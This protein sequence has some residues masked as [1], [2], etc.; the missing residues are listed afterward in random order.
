MLKFIKNYLFEILIFFL[1]IGI[2]ITNYVPGT[3]LIGWDSLQT[4]LYPWL[5][6]KRALFSV[7]QE[8]QSFGLVTGM[9]HAADIIRAIFLFLISFV[10]KENLVR[11]F[12]HHLMLLI[13][14][15]GAFKLFSFLGFKSKHSFL[16]YIGAVFYILNL[17]TVQIFALPFE[18]FSV[19]FAFLP[20]LIITF[21]TY[22]QST[23]H[24]RK[25]ILGFLIINL[26]ATPAFYQQ[27]MFIVYLIVISL[28]SFG[29]MLR[30]FF[31][32]KYKEI[33]R[34][35]KNS[36]FAIFFIV[37]INTFWILPQ[38]YSIRSS[39]SVTR[40][41]KINQL[42]TETVVNK[43]IEKGKL[44]YLARLE[45]FYYDLKDINQNYLFSSWRG[46]FDNKF[47]YVLSFIPF[48]F[49]V[50]GLVFGKK[51][52]DVSFASVF[53][54][55]FLIFMSGTVPF[56]LIWEAIRGLSLIGQIF[57]SP[58][59]KF[60]FPFSLVISYFFIVGLDVLISFIIR[61]TRDRFKNMIFYTICILALAS[62]FLLN[63]PAFRG[64]FFL[65]QMKLTLPDQYTELVTYFK[66]LDSNKRIAPIPDYTFW[67][68]Y[69]NDWG[70]DG[71]GFIWYGIEQPVISRTFD[72]WSRESEGYFWEMK[73]AVE[74]QNTA[75]FKSILNKYNINYLLVDKT[76]VSI[77]SA[78]LDSQYNRVSNMIRNVPNI[79]LAKS[80][81]DIDVYEVILDHLSDSFIFLSS[82]LNNVYPGYT[83][84]DQD[85]IHYS[86]GDYYFNE[87]S[88]P[89]II[90][91][92]IDF[93]NQT[94]KYSRKWDIDENND[95]FLITREVGGVDF[96]DYVLEGG[97]SSIIKSKIFD[98]KNVIYLDTPI[99]INVYGNIV[100][101]AVK[102]T[103][104]ES[105]SFKDIA[106]INCRNNLKDFGG[107]VIK[108]GDLEVHSKDRASACFSFGRPFLA[109][110]NGYLVKVNSEN[111]L[112][113]PL[114]FYVVGNKSN[115]QSKI[116]ENLKSGI[117]YYILGNGSYYDDGY[118]FGFQN[119]SFSETSTVNKLHSLEIYALPFDFIKKIKFIKR[120][121][122]V[123]KPIYSDFIKTRKNNYSKFTIL[124]GSSFYDTVVLNQAYDPGWVALCGLGKCDA[125]HVKV[126]NWANGWVF[127]NS[128]PNNVKLIFWPQYLEFLGFLLLALLLVFSFRYK[129]KA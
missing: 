106:F 22:I 58:F 19:F 50:V 30:D 4:E 6:V 14:G 34:I 114:L 41:S 94:E 7:W 81:G 127:K 48:V 17:G 66:G 78:D 70:Y 83:I 115:T 18:P 96:S 113:E 76:S 23:E 15:I 51:K 68:W 3:Y 101:L 52:Y 26:L 54:F 85:D 128:V 16:A 112:G 60:I 82:G 32:R 125:Q 40:Q 75:Y 38:F 95:S 57:R 27:T 43:N 99:S 39:A 126:N 92:F 42:A 69:Q 79:Y 116:E 55:T 12:F 73:R 110:W 35:L 59:T 129:E 45:N 84:T 11:Y 77:T 31:E 21:L 118:I 67:G 105:A 123:N 111:L 25:R 121:S 117:N 28:L 100:E 53:I 74:T 71:S 65:S 61:I 62:V 109:H 119:I 24:S 103:L 20:F 1:V 104:V 44:R 98:G 80:I 33:Y 89:N 72:V 124:E 47:L 5:A 87:N 37:L 10:L 91:P 86:F 93:T 13:G 120:D 36:I 107:S 2:F 122:L 29:L 46:H 108:N 63:L 49:A 9:A 102:K 90:T 88:A 97:S 56:S 8:Y 64:N